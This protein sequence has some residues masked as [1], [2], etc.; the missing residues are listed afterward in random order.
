MIVALLLWISAP[1]VL[2]HTTQIQHKRHFSNMCGMF[3][4]LYFTEIQHRIHFFIMCCTFFVFKKCHV[5][6][7]LR[8][9]NLYCTFLTSKKFCVQHG[10]RFFN[11]CCT[12]S[13]LIRYVTTLKTFEII[14]AITSKSIVYETQH[15]HGKGY[16]IMR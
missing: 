5:Q 10:L 16:A 3:F 7:R 11:L 8:I 2:I 4:E 13:S 9:L 6:H 15:R 12:S 14:I 1:S